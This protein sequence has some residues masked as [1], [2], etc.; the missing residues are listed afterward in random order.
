MRA[1]LGA[2]VLAVVLA[3]CNPTVTAAT[4]IDAV[5]ATCGFVLTENVDKLIVKYGSVEAIRDLVCG[6]VGKVASTPVV[7]P[8]IV[9]DPKADRQIGVVE[10]IPIVGHFVESKP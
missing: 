5:K 10:G 3:G 9:A 1:F 4:V 6:L 7:N 8:A 2:L